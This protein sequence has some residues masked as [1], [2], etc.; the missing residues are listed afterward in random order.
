MIS[1]IKS[2]LAAQE[3]FTLIE[4][5]VVIVIL[6]ILVAIAVPS[7]LS[8]RGKA[9]S[10]SASAN[11]RSA[12]PA[13]ESYY[14]DNTGSA[15]DIDGSATTT[16]YQG[17]TGALLRTEAPG[18]STTVTAGPNAT[19]TGYCIQ[20]VQGASTYYYTGGAGGSAT[21]TGGSGAAAATCP[22]G[23]TAT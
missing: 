3:G 15:T 21:I 14:Q 23:Y 8:F 22:A 12:I 9:E 20:A 16:Q 6:G 1:K 13:A 17:M 18:V 5:L 7:Y 11:V 19:G 2:R 4:L 10:A